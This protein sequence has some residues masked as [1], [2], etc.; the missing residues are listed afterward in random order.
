MSSLTENK[1]SKLPSVI[2]YQAKSRPFGAYMFM[3]E[4]KKT[5]TFMTGRNPKNLCWTNTFCLLLS[6]SSLPGLALLE[7]RRYSALLVLFIPN[8][9]IGYTLKKQENLFFFCI[10]Y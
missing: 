8:Y 1:P 10:S 6:N 3:P 4:I 2:N 5:Q 7:L 9:A